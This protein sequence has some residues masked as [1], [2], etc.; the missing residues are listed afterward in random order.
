MER[1]AIL[2]MENLKWRLFKFSSGQL[3][4]HIAMKEKKDLS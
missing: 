2:K 3:G 1:S 4:E